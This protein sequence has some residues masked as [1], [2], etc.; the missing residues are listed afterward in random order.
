MGEVALVIEDLSPEVRRD[1]RLLKPV[2]MSFFAML[3]WHYLWHREDGPLRR[4]DYA[5]LAAALV[6]EG[7]PGAAAALREDAAAG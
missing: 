5:R 2:T 1:R 3:N 7:L 6:M 4:A